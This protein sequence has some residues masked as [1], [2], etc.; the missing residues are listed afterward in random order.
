MALS[1][2]VA[3]RHLRR[4][5]RRKAEAAE[6]A[7]AGPTV[8]DAPIPVHFG[9]AFVP[10]SFEVGM[11][12]PGFLAELT[13]VLVD[14]ADQ[15]QATAYTTGS[16]SG[17]PTRFVTALAGTSSEINTRSTEA[18]DAADAYTLQRAATAPVPGQRPVG[19]SD[20][21]V[22]QAFRLLDVPTTA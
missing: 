11:D 9:D 1:L 18:I 15:L 16:G 7:D 8:D 6:V 21:V 14:A 17:Q 4:R 13:K 12:A 10:Y 3:G 2:A 20:V 19:G 5:D 22:D